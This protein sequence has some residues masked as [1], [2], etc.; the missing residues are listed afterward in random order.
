METG[1]WRSDITFSC[2]SK[3]KNK[4]EEAMK[5]LSPRWEAR[6]KFKEEETDFRIF[7]G[8]GFARKIRPPKAVGDD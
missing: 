3:E 4:G 2:H 8:N 5:I 7:Q 1:K 6:W